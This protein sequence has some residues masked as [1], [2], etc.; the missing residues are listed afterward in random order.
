MA[1]ATIGLFLG[2]EAPGRPGATTQNIGHYF[3]E[4]QRRQVYRR[5]ARESVE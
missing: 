5:C 3:K 1:V 2:V 4:E